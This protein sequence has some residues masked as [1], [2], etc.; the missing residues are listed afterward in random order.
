MSARDFDV[1]VLGA[2]PAGEVCAGRLAENGL[3]VALVER[4]LVGGECSFYAC[5]PSKALLRPAQW[6]A[7]A[8]RVPGAAEA[9]TGG[10]DVAA[11]LHRRDEV[12]HGLDDGAQLP[13]L[14]ARG[15]GPGRGHGGPGGER[16]V[17]VRGAVHQGAAGST[18]ASATAEDRGEDLLLRAGRAVVLA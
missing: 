8:L 2:G 5:M 16:A 11:A 4:E 17:R 14:E 13:W 3:A 9:L 12:G 1:I 6:L 7:E 10:L 18:S 15:G